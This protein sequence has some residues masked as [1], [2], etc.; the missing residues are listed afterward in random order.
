MTGVAARGAARLSVTEGADPGQALELGGAVPAVPGLWVD[1]RR[2]QQ[3]HVVVVVQGAHRHLGHTGERPDPE[4]DSIPT[5]SRDVRVKG[6]RL[7][8]ERAHALTQARSV[9]ERIGHSAVLADVVGLA[10]QRAE[11]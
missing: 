10:E 11:A 5:T 3:A 1:L 7:E 8:A 2:R 6:L 4:H 9:A